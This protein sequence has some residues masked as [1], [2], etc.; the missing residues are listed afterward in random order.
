MIYNNTEDLHFDLEFLKEMKEHLANW[1]ENKDGASRDSVFE[2]V[3]DWIDE[4]EENL[5][6][7]E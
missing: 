2:M 4:L 1:D 3:Q 5:Y 7:V 6:E